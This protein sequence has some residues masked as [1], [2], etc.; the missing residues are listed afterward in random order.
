VRAGKPE[1]AFEEELAGFGVE[2]ELVL[3]AEWRLM[4]GR[5]E[6]RIGVDSLRADLLR[7][8]LGMLVRLCS[9][10][11]TG[12]PTRHGPVAIV[13]ARAIA[14]ALVL[15]A[16]ARASSPGPRCLSETGT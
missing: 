15:N 2:V 9:A 6:E 5:E 4:V 13:G 7:E 10:T 8:E 12:V 3:V 11:N 16:V 14:I 1:H